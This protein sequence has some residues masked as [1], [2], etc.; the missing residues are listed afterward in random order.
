MDYT[1]NQYL[2]EKIEKKDGIQII[3]IGPGCNESAVR[4]E[5]NILC[6]E[7][8][9]GIIA[10]I[11]STNIKEFDLVLIDPVLPNI[12]DKDK[13]SKIL[14]YL[15][16][17]YLLS[18]YKIVENKKRIKCY[19]CHKDIQN[20]ILINIYL[21]NE[22]LPVSRKMI[23]EDDTPN[24]NWCNKLETLIELKKDNY[25]CVIVQNFVRYKLNK[26]SLPRHEE[27]LNLIWLVLFHRVFNKESNSNYK[28]LLRWT[29]YFVDDR[30]L[31]PFYLFERFMYL[32]NLEQ[33]TH[34][35]IHSLKTVTSLDSTNQ[36][37]I[38]SKSL[39]NIF[40]P[41]T[42]NFVGYGGDYWPDNKH[43]DG[44]PPADNRNFLLDHIHNLFEQMNIK[45]DKD[46]FLN[47]FK[48][49]NINDEGKLTLVN[50][51]DNLDISSTYT[52]IVKCNKIPDYIKDSEDYPEVP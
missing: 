28:I 4:Y 50:L 45:I 36:K 38:F 27:I 19:I 34:D 26:D 40:I 30:G 47:K 17:Y 49:Y 7:E 5:S 23:I 14:H 6:Y 8:L 25:G 32:E 44:D 3:S 18:N 31:P 1:F 22:S 35:F 42:Y 12:T 15:S 2:D 48:T 37:L 39:D 13:I 51:F 46:V 20:F 41:Y 52:E 16:S 29:G 43:R 10:V 9:F 33:N 11:L 24:D 21:F